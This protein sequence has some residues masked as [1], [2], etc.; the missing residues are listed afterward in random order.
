MATVPPSEQPSQAHDH[1]TTLPP[2]ILQQIASYLYATHNPCPAFGGHI[3]LAPREPKP[4]LLCLASASKVLHAQANNW[5]HHH[6]HAHRAIT[7]YKD[8]KTAAAA[9]RQRPLLKLLQ[10]SASHC[11]FCGKK[12]TRHAILM[13][14]LVCCA[15]CDRAAWPE[16][17]TKTEAKKKYRVTEEQLLP[18]PG[19]RAAPRLRY[20]TYVTAGVLATMFLRA[21]VER[22]ALLVKGKEKKTERK[23]RVTR[24]KRADREV[25]ALERAEAG[26][27]RAVEIR[28]V[29]GKDV[30]IIDDEDG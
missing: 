23:K 19:D 9:A 20:G 12:S 18:S 30:I 27:S 28:R 24:G 16:K 5:A 14:G 6:L 29:G 2:E 15:A 4:A 10:W 17:I 22:L 25:E 11:V 3:W 7:K 26:T 13:S 1:L 8:Y 21:D